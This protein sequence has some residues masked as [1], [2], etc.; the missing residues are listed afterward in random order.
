[1]FEVY[2]KDMLK[3][4]VQYWPAEIPLLVQLDDD[5][6]LEAV[7][8][9]L[10]PS[11][12]A[13]VGWTQDHADFVAR[14]KEKDHPHDY[15]KQ[16][17]R[18]CHKVFALHRALGAVKDERKM[19]E[20]KPPRYL[21]WMDADTITNRPVTI[22]DI[23][24]CLPKEGEAVSYMGRKDWPHSECGWLA[25]DLENEGDIW[26]DVWHGL[27]VSDEVLKLSETHDSWVFDHIRQSKES[28]R[29]TNLT[30]G[31]PGMDIW[32]HSPMGKWSSHKKGPVA[33]GLPTQKIPM[34][35]SNV[36]IKTK[37]AVP[38]EKI[39]SHI[40]ENQTLIKNWIRECTKTDEQIVVVSAGPQMVAEDVFEDYKAGKKIVAV[41]HALDRLK[42]ADITPWACI[43]LDPRPHVYD[44]VKDPDPN[45]IWFVASQVDPKVVMKL[46]AHGCEV[47]GY[48]AAVG[49]GEESLTQLQ[50]DSIISGGS[51]TA[52]RGL[53]ALKHLGFYRFKLFGY[54]LCFPDKVDLNAKDEHGQP[55][56]LEMSV[57]WNDP[58]SAMKKC[59]WSEPQLIAQ[60]EEFNNLIQGGDF[61]FE[62]VGD[63]I[64]PFVL[65][66]K[67]RGELRRA[68]LKAKMSTPVS[69]KKLL[70]NNRKKTRYSM[71][72]RRL[73]SLSRQRTTPPL[74]S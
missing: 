40:Q 8:K 53:F 62:A 26:I 6:V 65:K 31:Q 66:A 5:L 16:C 54:D 51:A 33:K 29:A 58:L 56:Y 38:D 42:A 37:N 19:P 50:P 11:D 3:S 4:F 32:P 20:G 27:Y 17:V 2:A 48:H 74:K 46:L 63:G 15:R 18:F 52:T 22:E 71:M 30:E 14:N 55:R 34:G 57:G 10:R 64:I 36:V 45:I 67:N 28:P 72:L 47:W 49:A 12:A 68:K 43:L 41:K 23:K 61:E 60:F 25:F 39:R 7:R 1:M 69:Y 9:I 59:F 21:I 35:T 73:L 24:Q 44:F 13:A 70:W